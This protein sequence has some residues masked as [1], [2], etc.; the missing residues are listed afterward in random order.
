MEY[1]VLGSVILSIY[2]VSV[3]YERIS[4]LK[5]V[6]LGVIGYFFTYI[7]G[8]ALLFWIGKYS[9]QNAVLVSFGIL[10]LG[11]II[12]AWHRKKKSKL[13]WYKREWCVLGLVLLI[14]L[15]M[16]INKF[17]FFGMG[18]DQGVYQTKAIELIYDNN[19]RIFDFEEYSQLPT[20]EHQKE[21]YKTV[22]G[23]P[24]YDVLNDNN[25][26][27]SGI[28]GKSEV[29]GIY[30]GIPVFPA[31][32]ALF[33]EMFGISHMQEC[34]TLFLILFLML[35]FYVLENFSIKPILQIAS[36]LLVGCA[37]LVLWTSK[38]ALTEM[39]LSVIVAAFVM[40]I[41]EKK[42]E[43]KFF[44][45]IPILVF[46]FYHV[47]I[48]TV[49]PMIV[50]L[51]W[52]LYIIS[53]DRRYIRNCSLSI[54]SYM[55][56]FFFMAYI[57]PQYTFNNYTRP[58]KMLGFVNYNTLMPF[59]AC[60]CVVAMVINIMLYKII[61]KNMF[62]KIR[63]IMYR[64]RDVI[65]KG[66]LAVLLIVFIILCIRNCTSIYDIG[67]VTLIAMVITTGVFL[68]PVILIETFCMSKE[69]MRGE[70]FYIVS[71]MF[72]YMILI[73]NMF[74]RSNLAY[75]YYYGR[76]L[77]PYM[78]IVVVLFCYIN[79]ER[80]HYKAALVAFLGGAVFI[81]PDFLL[82]TQVDDTRVSWKVL[83]GVLD[84]IEGEN[85]AV[86]VAN[87]LEDV[88]FLP[89]KSAGNAVFN[90]WE[91]IQSEVDFLS[92]K[93]E[94]VYYISND[95]EML[96]NEEDFTAIYREYGEAS[97]EI[98]TELQTFS[99][100]PLEYVQQSSYYTVYQYNKNKL[101]YG[102]KDFELLANGF[103]RA[104]SGTYAWIDDPAAKMACYLDK[105]D[106]VVVLQQGPGVPL[107]ELDRE[108]MDVDI[109]INDCHATTLKI[110]EENNSGAITF[111]LSK[112]LMNEGQNIVTFECEM[113]SPSEY[114]KQDNRYKGISVAEVEFIPAENILSYEVPKDE[115]WGS[116]FGNIENEA[117]A[118]TSDKPAEVKC[119]LNAETDYEVTLKLG[120]PIPLE[121]LSLDKLGVKVYINDEYLTRLSIDK[122]NNGK[123]L[124][125][126]VPQEILNK[127]E[128]II[129]FVSDVWSPE[130]YGADDDRKL[131]FAYGGMEFAPCEE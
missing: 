109:Y 51:Y 67:N 47:T 22:K 112:D 5:A 88:L 29:A 70:G 78:L 101:K 97:E 41:T 122:E 72:T 57:S 98:Q 27:L 130:Q 106:Y 12:F 30:H 62:F 2:I 115:F 15:P 113:W 23:L 93:Y 36:M 102:V 105:Q 9:I 35:I 76:Y 119:Y 52:G 31:I 127:G 108:N 38:S 40:L 4:A 24:G 77:V 25:P 17:E 125:F 18:Q 34:Q 61:V 7:I 131:G 91:E 87:E 84:N 107:K 82:A 10:L 118:W 6:V 80:K 65:Y 74:F 116:G 60:M 86:I 1:I 90:E 71:V 68:I 110:D 94:N 49:M 104:A 63:D 16:S 111:F 103:S 120:A 99:K 79:N 43:L 42:E 19:Q 26:M 14:V 33:G 50:V 11:G 13:F 85:S 20:E 92:D 83:E 28:A 48:Y 100:Y 126:R 117:F 46:S 96:A 56:G 37:P 123:E 81:E 95:G 58:L 73:Y 32:L 8:S 39:F 75:L 54:V 55:S 124:T 64:H 114:G 59:V 3:L 53:K 69:E 128:N 121:E 89:I 44:S 129:C 66:I 45:W 21:Y